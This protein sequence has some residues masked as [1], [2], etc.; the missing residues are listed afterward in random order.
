[1]LDATKNASIAEAIAKFLATLPPSQRHE[2]QMELNR[3]LRWFGGARLI[4][5]LTGHEVSR[6]GDSSTAPGVDVARRLEP[7]RA[8][9]AYA[10]KE[11]LTDTNLSVHLRP[12]QAPRRR[13]QSPPPNPPRDVS[14]SAEGYARLQQELGE[15][16]EERP[17]MAEELHRAMADKDFREN[18]PLDAARER[19][20]YLEARIRELEATLG[21]ATVQEA[22]SP[23]QGPATP[24]TS[25]NRQVVVS[26]AVLL[27]DLESGQEQRYTL[28]SPHEVN[29]AQRKISVAS[30]LGQALLDR[31]PG[32]IV[33]VRAPAGVRRYRLERIEG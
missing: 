11:K 16:K 10:H 30:P 12:Q 20:G 8:F 25:P 4:A 27:K 17:K 24:A 9:L 33:E 32:D 31:R 26:S 23:Q 21:A 6:Y 1:M 19:Q 3:F 7:V 2:F 5:G 22:S 14:L 18:A 15:L 29:L 13:R 28:V